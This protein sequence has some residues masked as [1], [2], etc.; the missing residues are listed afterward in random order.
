[1]SSETLPPQRYRDMFCDNNMSRHPTLRFVPGGLSY[2]CRH[3]KGFHAISRGRA[4]QIWDELEMMQEPP[5][6]ILEENTGG[7]FP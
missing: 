5:G 3:C 6:A 4:I 7:C 1:M 2:R